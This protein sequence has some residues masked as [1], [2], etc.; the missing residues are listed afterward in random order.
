MNILSGKK[1]ACCTAAISTLQAVGPAKF[2]IV[3][4]LHQIIQIFRWLLL[5]FL[6]KSLVF[7]MFVF[8]LFR[9]QIKFLDHA[10]KIQI[11]AMQSNKAP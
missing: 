4:F 11:H 8:C 10:V 5:Q 7:I 6:K 2:R 1:R 3:Q 9:K